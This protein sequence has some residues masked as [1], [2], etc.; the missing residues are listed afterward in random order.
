MCTV[1]QPPG[2]NPFAVNKYIIYPPVGL[3]SKALS[4]NDQDN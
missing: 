3:V 2:D 1:L 4:K